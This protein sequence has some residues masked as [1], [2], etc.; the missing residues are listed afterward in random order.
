MLKRTDAASFPEHRRVQRRVVAVVL[1]RL[2]QSFRNARRHAGRPESAAPA[3]CGWRSPG[4]TRAPAWG[5]R[6]GSAPC[7]SLTFGSSDSIGSCTRCISPSSPTMPMLAWLRL[8]QLLAAAHDLLEHRLRIGHR[9]ADDLQHLG[10]GGLPL[11]RL[12]RLVEQPRVLD[13]DQRL[14]AERLGQR[15]LVGAEGARSTRRQG[16]HANALV[17]AQQ[18]KHQRCD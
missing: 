2:A 12:L 15:D 10:R 11:Q 14:V 6:S 4:S 8:D 7:R 9:A 1:D 5:S 16:Q 18:G 17:C 3:A 13:G